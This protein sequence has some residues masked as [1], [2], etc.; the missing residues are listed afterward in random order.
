M[1]LEQKGD[2]LGYIFEFLK[3]DCYQQIIVV[4]E[5][6]IYAVFKMS[7]RPFQN[8]KY[9]GRIDLMNEFMTIE[10]QELV[11]REIVTTDMQ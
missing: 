8:M 9:T 6:K 11:K 7:S 10:V 4:Q 3:F 5:I 1:K 2:F